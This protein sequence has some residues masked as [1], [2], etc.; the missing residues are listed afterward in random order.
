MLL[1]EL[2]F[3]MCQ[4]NISNNLI[5]TA[6]HLASQQLIYL[7][8]HQHKHTKINQALNQANY[9]N[10]T[11]SVSSFEVQIQHPQG[12]QATRAS[13]PDSSSRETQYSN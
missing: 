4:L 2:I 13:G 6:M 7:K 8:S 12:A 3:A 1:I 5:L 11:C 9:E 10:I